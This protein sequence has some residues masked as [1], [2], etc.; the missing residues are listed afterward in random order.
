MQLFI[1][2]YHIQPIYVTYIHYTICH[3]FHVNPS[4]NHILSHSYHN[5]YHHTIISL[6]A[7]ISSHLYTVIII[8]IFMSHLHTSSLQS[9]TITQSYHYIRR[10]RFTTPSHTIIIPYIPN[11]IS[12]F[13]LISRYPFTH[14]YISLIY[15]N[16]ALLGRYLFHY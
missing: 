15:R 6:H 14:I 4:R 16:K 10:H 9:F 2:F 11:I 3:L 13:H 5:H 8:S 1:T 12:H 7:Y